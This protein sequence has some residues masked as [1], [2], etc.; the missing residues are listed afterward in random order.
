VGGKGLGGGRGVRCEEGIERHKLRFGVGSWS[1]PVN[2]GN[3]SLTLQLLRG[4]SRCH[5]H[6]E[7]ARICCG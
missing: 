5:A 7:G 4:W 6:P 2:I 3:I 1:S